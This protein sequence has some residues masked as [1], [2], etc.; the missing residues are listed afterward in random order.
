[1]PTVRLPAKLKKDPLVDAVFEIRFSSALP[2]SSVIPGILF[3]TLKGNSQQIERLPAFDIPS[4]MRAAN[5]ALQ[6][7]PLMRMHWNDNY[8]ILIGDVSLGLGCKIPYPG[9]QSFKSH[10]IDLIKLINPSQFISQIERYSLKYTGIID[11]KDLREQTSRIKLD[12][13]FGT[14]TS[15]LTPDTY[16]LKSDP[17]SLRIEMQRDPFLY[18]M[19]LAAPAT[20]NFPDGKQR[21]GLMVDID[22]LREHKTANLGEF[23]NE[24]PTR[25]EEINTRN[26]Q[27]FFGLL[28]DETLAYLEP[29]YDTISG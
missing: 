13:A 28:T 20:A 24:L 27:L 23:I 3:A 29:I 8:L 15:D 21:T 6:S 18:V 1:M 19:N 9:W 17:F 5:P 25:V 10:I 4:Q 26:K 22:G 11:G 7:Q 12:L 16:N 14:F 2:A